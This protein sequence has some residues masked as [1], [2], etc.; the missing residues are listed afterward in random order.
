[1]LVRNME[2]DRQIQEKRTEM[3]EA[4]AAHQKAREAAAQ[5]RSRL[6]ELRIAAGTEA[7][8]SDLESLRSAEA[9]AQ[10]LESAEKTAAT[11][12]NA[13]SDELAHL[14]RQKFGA[15]HITW[16]GPRLRP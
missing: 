11:R 3:R 12:F 8:G 16:T 10:E 13:V 7:A 2:L 14:H 6:S 1:M 5:M 15:W 9:Q 4:L